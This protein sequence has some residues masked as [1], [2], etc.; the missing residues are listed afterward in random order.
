MRQATSLD[1]KRAAVHIA[2][3]IRQDLARITDAPSLSVSAPLQTDVLSTLSPALLAMV[4]SEFDSLDH[5]FYLRLIFTLTSHPN[6]LPRLEED[7]HINRCFDIMPDFSDK[8]PSSFFYLAGIF[9]RIEA[10]SGKK[11]AIEEK[12]AAGEQSAPGEMSVPGQ[13]STLVITPS[14]WWDLTMMAWHVAGHSDG[15][16]SDVL[17]DSDGVEILEALI[18]HTKSYMPQNASP[19]DLEFLCNGLDAAILKMELRQ[20]P[21]SKEIIDAM[22][23]MSR[24]RSSAL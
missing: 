7:G 12:S 3:R 23:D 11:S 14:Q 24:L 19:S 4:P 13:Q 17:D 18:A 22:K 20:P 5:F 8:P 9:L 10:A 6:W 1:C 2:Y 21:P 16:D 15:P